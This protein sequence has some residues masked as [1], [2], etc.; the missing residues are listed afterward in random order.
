MVRLLMLTGLL[1]MSFTVLPQE[2]MAVS[3]Q[4]FSG[5]IALEFDSQQLAAVGDFLAVSDSS[6]HQLALLNIVLDGQKRWLT[7][8]Q[9]C[10]GAR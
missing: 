3:R 8:E 2:K 6:G 4:D 9:R 10:T 5:G 7:D 1:A